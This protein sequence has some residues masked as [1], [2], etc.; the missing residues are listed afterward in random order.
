MVDRTW[1][2]KFPTIQDDGDL[3]VHISSSTTGVAVTTYP[4]DGVPFILDSDA[5]NV[6]VHQ[7]WEHFLTHHGFMYTAN[8]L[9]TAIANDAKYSILFVTGP[10]KRNHLEAVFQA[11]TKAW[12]SVYAGVTASNNGTLLDPQ[13]G[14][15]KIGDTSH[16]VDLTLYHT[17]TISVNGTFMGGHLVGGGT[18]ASPSGGENRAGGGEWELQL[19]TKYWVLVEAKGGAGI[20]TDFDLECQ[21]YTEPTSIP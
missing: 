3:K 11:S 17:P 2:E 9:K 10:T 15:N 5:L 8:H 16:P 19:S 18:K 1:G 14:C 6:P 21:V 7:T 4:A 13:P 12:V 20:T